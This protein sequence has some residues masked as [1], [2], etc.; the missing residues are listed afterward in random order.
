M[1]ATFDPMRT[2]AEILTE[3]GPLGEDDIVRRLRD[4]GVT[5]T[6]T[7]LQQV[8]MEIDC[9]ARQLVDDRWIWLPHVLNG[10]VF[11]HRVGADEAAHDMLAATPDL[12]PIT[13]LCD[14]EHYQRLTDGSAVQN[15]LVGYDDDLLEQ[16]GIPAEVVDEGGVLLLAPGTLGGL[17][18]VAGD[19]VGVRLTEQGLAVERVSTLADAAVGARLAATLDPDEPEF[20]DAAVWT[21]CVEDPALFK[22]PSPPLGEIAADYGLAHRGEWLAPGGFD[23]DHWEFERGCARLA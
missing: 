22:E 2:L 18:V 12:D 20:F 17:G 6:D 16:L 1:A 21:A 4:A 5:D 9:P 13:A 23:F 11:T 7:V 19:L 3:H 10:R 15:V 8:R 14:F